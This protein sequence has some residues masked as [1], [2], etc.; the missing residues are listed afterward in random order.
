MA[1]TRAERPAAPSA[2]LPVALLLLVGAG[3]AVGLGV[4][5]KA[6]TP[7]RR[8]LFLLG[9]SGM[10]QMKAWLTTVALVLIVVQLLTALWMWG[11][12]PGAAAAPNGV[13]LIHRWS[14]TVA[15]VVTLPVAFHCIWSL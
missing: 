7:A 14:G 2:A 15:F 6:H 1:G 9:F 5:A 13:D 4:Y 8:P 3:V 11:N 12:L 10:L